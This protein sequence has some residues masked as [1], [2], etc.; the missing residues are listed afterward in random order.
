MSVICNECNREIDMASGCTVSQIILE[1]GVAY[2]RILVDAQ[3]EYEDA[4]CSDCGAQ[5]G[6]F[7]H[8]GCD[9]ERCPKCGGQMISC[10]CCDKSVGAKSG[11][12]IIRPRWRPWK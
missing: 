6:N 3:V 7:H 12:K 10:N 11:A 1:D 9:Q 4:R 2:D 5:P 8:Y